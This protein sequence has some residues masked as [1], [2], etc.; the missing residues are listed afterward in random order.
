MSQLD[1]PASDYTSLSA[2]QATQVSLRQA[3]ARLDTLHR[4]CKQL[5]PLA[6][7]SADEAKGR[8]V[9][10]PLAPKAFLQ[11]RTTGAQV[12]VVVPS[13]PTEGEGK[14][15]EKEV[16]EEKVDVKTALEMLGLRKKG[17]SS[18]SA[19]CKGR[20]LTGIL[21]SGVFQQA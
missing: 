12:R 18:F 19:E 11:A 10:V 9:Q 17:E 8:V 21:I 14:G 3:R 20:E 5:E 13:K 2:I 1:A 16:R 7:S 4:V 15:K 6:A